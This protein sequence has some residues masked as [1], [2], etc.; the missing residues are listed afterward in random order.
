MNPING[1]RGNKFIYE[2]LPTALI[3]Q[4]KAPKVLMESD[5]PLGLRS[6]A[7]KGN[8]RQIST[9]QYGIKAQSL[10]RSVDLIIGCTALKFS[11][12]YDHILENKITVTKVV[13]LELKFFAPKPEVCEMDGNF[14]LQNGLTLLSRIWY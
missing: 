3:C 11:V 1:I 7:K 2:M 9:L 4:S 13:S 6:S 5:L 12:I 14:R 10:R 8:S